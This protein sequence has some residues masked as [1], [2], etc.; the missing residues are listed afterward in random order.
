MIIPA[1]FLVVHRE[2]Y[3]FLV[4]PIFHNVMKRR[5]SQTIGLSSLKKKTFSDWQRTAPFNKW[6]AHVTWTHPTKTGSFF[7]VRILKVSKNIRVM[8][9][10]SLL[11]TLVLDTLYPVCHRISS[12]I[13][14]KQQFGGSTLHETEILVK[15]QWINKGFLT[16]CW[17]IKLA[18]QQLTGS[19]FHERSSRE[20]KQQSWQQID[21]TI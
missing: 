1:E 14:P 2:P 7:Y 17:Q 15:Q 19:K 21:R 13:L 4:R 20:L 3:G 8:L 16:S 12:F 5:K 9:L 10:T 11:L 6:S 18:K